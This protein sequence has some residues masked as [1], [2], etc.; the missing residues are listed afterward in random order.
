MVSAECCCRAANKDVEGSVKGGNGDRVGRDDEGRGNKGASEDAIQKEFVYQLS[1]FFHLLAYSE[2]VLNVVST[3]KKQKTAAQASTSALAISS[4]EA[5]GES[6]GEEGYDASSELRDYLNS[7]IAAAAAATSR[8]SETQHDKSRNKRRGRR[9]K[10]ELTNEEKREKRRLKRLADINSVQR[11]AIQS[12]MTRV[13]S[14]ERTNDDWNRLVSVMR[15]DNRES[16]LGTLGMVLV[17]R[18][19]GGD[20]VVGEGDGVQEGI[21]GLQ[22]QST[23]T[24]NLEGEE[25]RRAVSELGNEG[26]TE[27]LTDRG[28]DGES[29]KKSVTESQ[30]E[31]ITSLVDRTRPGKSAEELLAAYEGREGELLKNLKRMEGKKKMDEVEKVVGNSGGDRGSSSTGAMEKDYQA[32]EEAE[33]EEK[34]PAK[35]QYVVGVG[36]LGP[37]LV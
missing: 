34:P 9:K 22:R 5:I 28:A 16:Y 6:M 13:R 19:E 17:A 20:G 23:A 26:I 18:E 12:F 29:K 31:E 27:G 11:A 32:K 8:D 4:S 36:P 7:D 14:G 3:T 24:G 1:W 33:G 35:G 37:A 10:K 30:K 21:G 15:E 2:D 25:S